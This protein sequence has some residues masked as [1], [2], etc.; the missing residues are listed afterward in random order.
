MNNFKQR[1]SH[2]QTQ[3]RKMQ[4][5]FTLV[6]L[7]VAVVIIGILTSMGMALMNVQLANSAISATKQN[8]ETIKD[9]LIWYLRTNKRLPCP[10]PNINGLAT[11]TTPPACDTYFGFVPYVELGLPR[12]VAL[13]GWDN[14]FSYSVTP[15]WTSAT[16]FHTEAEPDIQIKTRESSD[17]PETNL[18]KAV[19]AVI[20]Y[21]INGS[22]AYT[23]K[24]R[25]RAAP[26]GDDEIAN[27]LAASALPLPVVSKTTLFQ[28]DF[29]D[30]SGEFGIFD[31]V[32]LWLSPSHLLVPLIKDGSI[33]NENSL[34]AE[35]VL[36]I[37]DALVSYML[38][39]PNCAPPSDNDAFIVLLNTRGISLKDPWLGDLTYQRLITRMDSEGVVTPVLPP[40][41]LPPPTPP[42][43]YPYS[44]TTSTPNKATYPPTN[45]M[46][47]IK[48]STIVQNKC[49]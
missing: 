45:M 16:T 31:D 48:Y 40:P 28:R 46:I 6:E 23:S 8:Q 39:D 37:N 1:Y 22:G 10:A 3:S 7:A 14:F 26:E 15:A 2:L 43:I 30:K 33:K 18:G 35:Q 32:V 5:G 34:W 41:P 38:S 27:A 19:V 20:S 24:G 47:Y 25:Q 12:S 44:I 36:Q 9:A 17:A 21:G 29:T 4:V 42:Y 13:D 49:P 11:Q